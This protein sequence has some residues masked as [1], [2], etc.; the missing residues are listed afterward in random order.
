MATMVKTNK[1]SWG[2]MKT[3]HKDNSFSIPMHP[4]HH[5]PI[6]KLKDGESHSFKD[7]TGANWKATR[8]GEEV[9]FSGKH[10][11]VTVAHKEMFSEN[12]IHTR[13]TANGVEVVVDQT[14]SKEADLHGEPEVPTKTKKKSAEMET[15]ACKSKK[16]VK[17]N[18]MGKSYNKF[19]TELAEI[20][21]G[22]IDDLRDRMQAKKDA[23]WWGDDEK[24]KPGAKDA[25]TKV[26]GSR[27]GGSKQKADDE[28]GESPEEEDK[29]HKKRGKYGARNRS[30]STGTSG[31]TNDYHLN[32]PSK[33]VYYK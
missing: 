16:T 18:E 17:E 21:E 8:N 12:I 2:T 20:L 1:Y 5:E 24:K 13:K 28:E 15:E 4:E 27:Y 22:K 26:K 3:I 7:E 30:G 25:V 31:G 29:E 23:D 33:S 32:L 9:N 6:A 19:M 10:G 11:H 14:P